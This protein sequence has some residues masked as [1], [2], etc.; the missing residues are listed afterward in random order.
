MPLVKNKRKP[1]YFKVYF[2]NYYSSRYVT[3]DRFRQL[4]ASFEYSLANREFECVYNAEISQTIYTFDCAEYTIED[5]Y[6]DCDAKFA[7]EQ[8]DTF[9]GPDYHP[10]WLEGSMESAT[11][12]KSV[13]NLLS[14]LLLFF[15]IHECNWTKRMCKI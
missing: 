7:R 9:C 15:R 13:S 8:L 6:N 10:I 5:S 4:G 2:Q 14:L 11:I 12:G 3:E 1:N